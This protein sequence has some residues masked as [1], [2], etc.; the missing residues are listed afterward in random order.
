MFFLCYVIYYLFIRLGT[1]NCIINSYV[2]Y[3]LI[4]LSMLL[5]QKKDTLVSR[6]KASKQH[7]MELGSLKFYI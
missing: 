6:F 3:F 7:I 1:N 5:L 2:K 4:T